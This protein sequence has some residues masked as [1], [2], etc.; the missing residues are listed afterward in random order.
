[1]LTKS[2]LQSLLQCPRKLWLE[3]HRPDLIPSD[4][5]SA[6]RRA[7]D[8][9]IVGAKAREQLGA[10]FIWPPGDEDK[11]RAAENARQLMAEA[12]DRP[13][14]EAPFLRDGLYARADALVPEGGGY[15]LRETKAS[16]FPLKKD[17]VTTANPEDHHLDDVAIQ[18]WVME[19]SNLKIIRAE[20]NLLNNRW[21][22]A[23]GGD[24]AGL[25][26][27]LDVS[28]D[29]QAR[30]PNVP[31]WLTQASEVVAGAMPAVVTGK[32]CKAPYACPFTAFCE[33]RDPPKPPHPIEL[34]PD[35]AGK[36]LAK[37]LRETRGYVSLLEPAPEEFTG[38]AAPLY[39]RMQRAHA[40]GEAVI[41]PGTAEAMA[42]FPYP[43]YYFDFEG[44]DLPVPRW[45]GV[46]PY[47]QIPFQWSCHIEREPRAFEHAEFLDLTGDDPSLG[48]IAKMHEVIDPDDGG[49][50]FVYYANYERGRLEGLAQRHPEHSEMLQTYL[51][52]LVDL[53]PLVK[54]HYYHPEMRGSFSIKKV[55]A[56]I[57][58]ELDYAELGEVQE[59][60]G[61]QVAYL[62]AVFDP[63]TTP[64]RKADLE[65]K[66]RVYCKQDTWAMV[67][68]AYFLA[69][70]GRPRSQV[71]GPNVET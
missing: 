48:C 30:K 55:L 2:D 67:E 41:E 70:A 63:A 11:A 14:A 28:A 42:K 43:R 61:A 4:D 21:Q 15:V 47:E 20:L 29:V 1:M 38:K 10:D 22:Y 13:A 19:T 53:H 35:L 36:G 68:I 7:I 66:L 51:E 54:E 39:R 34:L 23:G 58:P 31:L 56:V 3:H 44:I 69:R 37:K 33:P 64:E 5:P 65:H 16:T 24:Y 45:P 46:R 49:P 8:G 52:R 9:N 60:T 18:A 59:G 62:Y 27:Q 12:P 50:I 32:Q 40:T 17:K 26:R 25:F 71:G 57:A 6:Y